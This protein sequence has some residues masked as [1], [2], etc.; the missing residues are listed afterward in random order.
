MKF[1]LV[2]DYN[3]IDESINTNLRKFLLS[4]VEL[5]NIDLGKS[6]PLVHHTTKDRTMNSLDDLVLMDDHD[7]RSMHAKYRNK[8]R[9][10]NA[11]KPYKFIEI[12]DI[13]EKAV[14]NLQ[15][16]SYREETLLDNEN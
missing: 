6:N 10:V 16:L 8:P 5:A 14:H 9:D 13:L 1:K 7:H 11:H 4:L 12:K 15:Q 3:S 2:E